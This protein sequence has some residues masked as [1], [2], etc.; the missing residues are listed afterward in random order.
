MFYKPLT[1]YIEFNAPQKKGELLCL[2]VLGQLLEFLYPYSRCT[3]THFIELH[4]L[5]YE[6]GCSRMKAEIYD[7]R[8]KSCYNIDQEIITD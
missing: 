6:N 5:T 3:P 4:Y 8:G 2:I 7:L 1:K